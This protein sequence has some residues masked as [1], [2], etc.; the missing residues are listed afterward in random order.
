MSQQSTDINDPIHTNTRVPPAEEGD[1]AVRSDDEAESILDDRPV[2]VAR[3]LPV[4]TS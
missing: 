2:Q 1:R 3:V 4:V